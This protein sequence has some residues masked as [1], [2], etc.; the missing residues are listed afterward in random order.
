MGIYLKENEI[1]FDVKKVG[2]PGPGIL[3]GDRA[4]TDHGLFG[5]HSFGNNNPK[6]GTFGTYCQTHAHYGTPVH[7]YG[8]CRWEKRYAGGNK[9]LSWVE[10]MKFIALQINYGGTVSGFDISNKASGVA[11]V[12][13]NSAY[14]EYKRDSTN[15]QVSI[16]FADSDAVTTTSQEG[17]ATPV[18]VIRPNNEVAT[19]YKSKV[20]A[21]A[22]PKAG[23]AGFANVGVDGFYSIRLP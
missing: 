11:T 5:F 12:G 19:P 9:F 22:K 4:Q 16:R 8:S 18:R 13:N 7:L 10:E 6:G 17:V 15:S 14:L 1:G 3:H 2:F 21:S 20:V 23:G